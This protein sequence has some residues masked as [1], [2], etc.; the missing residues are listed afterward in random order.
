MSGRGNPSA[1]LALN[2][3]C[4]RDRG[5]TDEN[6]RKKVWQQTFSVVFFRISFGKERWRTVFSAIRKMPAQILRRLW[7]N[8]RS[9]RGLLFP[10]QVPLLQKRLE[11]GREHRAPFP[12]GSPL[13]RGF[14]GLSPRPSG[15]GVSARRFRHTLF[16]LF[17]YILI[18]QISMVPKAGLEPARPCEH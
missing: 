8:F 16:L 18:E 3:R 7:K 11:E 12:E 15:K 13:T 2:F 17:F 4:P 14:H 10:Q 5:E 9:V 6:R 1:V